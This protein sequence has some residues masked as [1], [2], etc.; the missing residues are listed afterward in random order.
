M[1]DKI[2]AI[3]DSVSNPV[4]MGSKAEMVDAL[5]DKYGKSWT[6]H[7]ASIISNNA[8]KGSTEYKSAMR[9]FQGERLNKEFT[10]RSAGK[11][12]RLAKSLPPVGYTPKSDSITVTLK[13][14]QKANNRGGTRERT[15]TA[16]FSGADAVKFVNNPSAREIFRQHFINKGELDAIA[17][18][19][20]D[21]FDDGD[22]AMMY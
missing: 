16:T 15:F 14:T 10:S 22:Y 4:Y 5:K 11:G 3:A 21:M 20:A 17:D 18:S 12:E 13:G 7:A 2:R 19:L 1:N 9:H 8:P 6:S